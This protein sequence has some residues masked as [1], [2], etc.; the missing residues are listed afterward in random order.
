MK[1]LANDGIAPEGAK[2]LQD[3]GFEVLT[4]KVDQDSLIDH[5][6]NEGIE[7]LLVRS[8]TKVRENLID[9]CPGLKL[10]GRGGVGMDNI[11]VDYARS[12]GIKVINTPGASSQSVAELVIAHLFSV[13]R[14]LYDSNREMP[15]RGSTEFATLK[16]AYSKGTELRG[17]TIGI[18]GFG[19]IGQSVAKYAL[20]MGMKVIAYDAIPMTKEIYLEFFDS[21]PVKITLSTVE[22]DEV[23]KNSDFITLH[24]PAQADGSPVIGEKEINIMKDGVVLVNASRGGIIDESALFSALESGKIAG[25]ALDVFAN[26]PTPRQELL[27]HKKISFTP[28]T[29]AATKEAQARVGTELAQQIIET[30]QPA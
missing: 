22:M 5:I 15:V 24:T 6:N 2:A 28:H 3:A 11:D 25:A 13:S 23:L 7:M 16:K 30:F 8:A 29:G 1:I 17:K 18:V 10:I 21:E 4:D 26:E 12:K 9:A 19:R 20:G 14:F 27:S